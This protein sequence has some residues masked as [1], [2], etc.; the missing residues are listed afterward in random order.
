MSWD[1]RNCSQM[2]EAFFV[3][4]CTFSFIGLSWQEFNK[5]VQGLK[6]TAT[7]YEKDPHVR[8]N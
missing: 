7:S 8:Y 5:Y 1:K 6:S 2:L 4:F 3:V